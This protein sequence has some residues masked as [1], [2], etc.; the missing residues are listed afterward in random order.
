M[1]NNSMAGLQKLCTEKGRMR[2]DIL[3]EAMP[4]LSIGIK[5]RRDTLQAI[6]SIC[7][8]FKLPYTIDINAQEG[9]N[10][11]FLCDK[12]IRREPPTLNAVITIEVRDITTGDV[13]K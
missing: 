13:M 11:G 5:T 4:F 9:N 7:D 1:S 2:D 3:N 6:R 12:S 8:Q 10:I